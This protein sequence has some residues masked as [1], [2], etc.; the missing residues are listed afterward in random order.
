LCL[1]HR[2][3]NITEPLLLCRGDEEELFGFYQLGYSLCKP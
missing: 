3:R 2:G 1:R